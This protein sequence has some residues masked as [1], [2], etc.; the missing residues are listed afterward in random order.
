MSKNYYTHLEC[1]ECGTVYDK[2]SRHTF[3][4]DDH[5]PLVAKYKLDNFWSKESL[6]DRPANMWRYKEVLPVEKEENRICLGE[7]FTPMLKLSKLGGKVGQGR[8]LLKD[9]SANPTGS[10]KARGISMALSKAKELGVT[11]MCI[12]T[13]GNAGSALSAYCAKAGMEAHIFM[14]EKTPHVFQMDCEIMGAKVTKVDGDISDAAALMQKE[15]DGSWF[16]VTTLKEPFRL[17]GKK[18]MGYEIAEQLRW[19]LPDVVVYPTGGGTGLIGIW[20]AFQE[21][22]DM[23]WIDKIPTRMVAVQGS[24][25]DPVVQAFQKGMDHTPKYQNPAKTIANGLRVPKAFGDKLIMKTLYESKGTAVS[26]TDEEMKEGLSEFATQEGVFLSPEG[27]AVW[28]GYKKLRSE[29]WIK[30]DESV[31]LINTGS[32]YKYV[33]NLY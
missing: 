5:Q 2:D 13:A 7:G 24:G 1:H 25:C 12:P 30:E 23:G 11:A 27:A 29:N 14:P 9:E 33:E 10:F 15:N 31:V 6:K 21:M 4:P 19:E 20:K 8:L 32:A 26:I 28:M 22:K 17:E 18:T 3:C 16:D